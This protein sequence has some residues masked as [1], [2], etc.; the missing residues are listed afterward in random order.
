MVFIVLSFTYL[1]HNDI[2]VDNFVVIDC[3]CRCP[4]VVVAIVD[5]LLSLSCC[6]GRYCGCDV[7]FVVVAYYTIKML[8]LQIHYVQLA[9]RRI[10]MAFS[11]E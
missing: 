11:C 1:D 4:V 6:H 3:C 10:N 5:G 2:V 8:F 7:V 9:T